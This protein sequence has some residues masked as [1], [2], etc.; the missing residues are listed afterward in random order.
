[1]GMSRDK[2]HLSFA[3]LARSDKTSLRVFESSGALGLMDGT[4]VSC[5]IHP[6]EAS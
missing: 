1:M 4:T 6:H 3:A 2:R 5:Q